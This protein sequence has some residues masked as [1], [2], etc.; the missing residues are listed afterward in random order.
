[1]TTDKGST[2][3]QASRQSTDGTFGPAT[4]LTTWDGNPI[5]ANTAENSALRINNNESL[6]L[7]FNN[8]SGAPVQLSYFLFDYGRSNNTAPATISLTFIDSN[9]QE[10]LLFSDSNTPNTGSIGDYS[11][12]AVNLSSY[13]IA[14]G[15]FFTLRLTATNGSSGGNIDNTALTVIPEPST[16]V[17]IFGLLVFAMTIARRRTK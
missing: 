6:N 14:A 13:T 17:A 1:M 15:D 16:Y 7:T 9:N 8:S 11:D 4:N 5:S 10:T 2:V 3:K 12:F